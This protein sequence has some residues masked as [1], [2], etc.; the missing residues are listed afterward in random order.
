MFSAVTSLLISVAI[1]L[2][3]TSLRDGCV[4]GTSSVVI[5]ILLLKCL[6]LSNNND[7]ILIKNNV[8]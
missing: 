8:N 4:W 5:L 1:N 2:A 7:K 6:F 3:C